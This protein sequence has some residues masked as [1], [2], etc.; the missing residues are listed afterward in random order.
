MKEMTFEGYKNYPVHLYVWDEVENPKAVVQLVHGMVEYLARYD[1]FAKY[2]N[3]NGFIVLGDDHRAHGKTA[4]KQNLGIAPEE[5]CYWDTIEDLKLINKFAKEKYGLPIYI[6]GHSYGSF[7]TQGFLQQASDSVQGAILSGSAFKNGIDS[8]IGRMIANVQCAFCGKDKRANF[9]KKMSFDAFDKE[10]SPSVS[11][12][13]GNRDNAEREKYLNDEMCVFVCSLGF[14]KS[15]FNALKVICKD[16][17]L[18]KIRKDLPIYI[19][20]GD[21]DPVGKYGEDVKKLY[22]KYKKIGIKNVDMKLYEGARHEIL[23][24]INKKEVYGDVL[25]FLNSIQ[26]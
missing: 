20:S 8:K 11:F 4:G 19:I 1:E 7:L 15:L 10:F 25:A 24:E 26:N 9:I 21:C 23:N 3:A 18:D 16:K 6:F 14:Y 22:D 12:A 2:L 17:N 13:W 5:D